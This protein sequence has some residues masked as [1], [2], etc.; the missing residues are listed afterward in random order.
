M[1]A[2]PRRLLLSVILAA[3]PAAAAGCFYPP[4]SVPPPP[5]K[6][7]TVVN[8]PYDLAWD[9]VNAVVAQEGMKVQV[10][11]P[12]QGIIEAQGS[13]F[14]L[15]DADCGRIRSV[16]G[17]YAAEPRIDATS[18]FNFHVRALTNETSE[19]AV[20]GTFDSPLY[21]PLR[22][23]RDVECVSRGAQESRLLRLILARASRTRPP[24]YHETARAGP[25]TAHAPG[26]SARPTSARL[27]PGRPTLLKPNFLPEPKER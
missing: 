21:V 11:N 19:V 1:I 24:A 2:D 7:S 8:L 15:Q 16:A 13:R 9:A 25:S 12:N 3:L 4:V 22:R 27:L 6:T 10:R 26:P 17:T 20:T 23:P 14:S 18:V 5:A